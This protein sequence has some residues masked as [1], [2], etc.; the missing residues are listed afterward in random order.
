MTPEIHQILDLLALPFMQRALLGGILTGI[1]G[2]LLGSFA[3]LRQLAFFSDTLGHSALLGLVIGILL[4]VDPH[5]VLFPFAIFFALVMTW[6]VE[7]VPLAPDALLNIVYSSSLALAIIGLTV[8]DIYQG[9]LTQILFGDILAV[10]QVD[11]W[12]SS[13]LLVICGLFLGGS[14]RAQLLSTLHEP[15]AIA[16]GVPVRGQRWIF[17]TL[18][19]LV[20]GVSIRSVGVLLVS[21]F[22]VIP[23]STARLLSQNFARYVALAMGIGGISA[24]LGMMG[25]AA[26]NL[27]SGPSIVTTQV[28]LFLLS[29]T[30]RSRS[31]KITN[32]EKWRG[33]RDH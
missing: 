27:P 30:F 12:L 5:W 29:L 9:N 20:V 11:L 8:A 15:L 19:A 16:Q 3:I 24:L 18:L 14:W 13:G 25:S 31:L 22:I 6:L 7:K 10:S 4:G 1:L 2:G 26:Y 33:H 32:G 21:A 17:V 23:A 28:V